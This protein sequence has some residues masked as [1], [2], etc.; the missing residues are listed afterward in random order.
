VKKRKRIPALLIAQNDRAPVF[1]Y[2][3]K[4]GWPNIAI[5]QLLFAKAGLK[6]LLK[7][8]AG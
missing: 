7:A 2:Q 1:N 6:N 5:G 4:P 3:I 8:R